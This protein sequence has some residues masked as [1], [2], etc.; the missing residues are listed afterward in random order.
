MRITPIKADGMNV[1]P[2][3][4]VNNMPIGK[5]QYGV[6]GEVTGEP[7]VA[8]TDG[9][10]VKAGDK[11]A[12]VGSGASKAGWV[13]IVHL[14]VK[15]CTEDIPAPTPDPIPPTA[16]FPEDYYFLEAPNGVRVKYVKEA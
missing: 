16:V 6:W 5:L 12:F 4:D 3:H 15:Y 7:W 13:A 2:S 8:P 1:R 11:W 10:N 14:G 9:L